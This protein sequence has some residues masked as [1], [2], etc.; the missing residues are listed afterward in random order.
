MQPGPERVRGLYEEIDTSNQAKWI[1][2]TIIGFV[3]IVGL[4][5]LRF[6]MMPVEPPPFNNQ[7]DLFV[8]IGFTPMA[9]C[10]IGSLFGVMRKMAIK[11]NPD[12]LEFTEYERELDEFRKIYYEA[13]FKSNELGGNPTFMCGWVLSLT[14]SL[15][16]GFFIIFWMIDIGSYISSIVEVGAIAVLYVLGNYFGY[17]G[18]YIRSEMVR[19][20]LFSHITKYL[21]KYDVLK[22]MTQ[23]DLISKIIVRY[24]FGKGQSLKVIDDI[25][26]FT[27]TSTEPPLDVEITIDN[28]ENIGP[29]YTFFY[30]DSL[31]T[32]RDVIIDVAGRDAILTVGEIEMRS[33][34]RLRY[35]TGSLKSKWNLGTPER[36]CDL[37]HAIVE[38]VAKEISVSKVPNSE[39]S[40][41]E[42]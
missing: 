40:H 31:A 1:L 41:L 27:V 6:F 10:L 14:V 22:S 26:V 25:H 4:S 29:E 19:D 3:V 9:S 28:M 35:D 38:E 17:R 33:F 15:C 30:S 34:I 24:K 36:L 20:P 23:C 18:G 37:M 13:D 39:E 12:R 32:R 21:S 11:I 8:I 5:I 7:V 16:I 42:E 2:P